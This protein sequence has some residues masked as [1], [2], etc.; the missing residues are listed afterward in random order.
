[1]DDAEFAGTCIVG[2]ECCVIVQ[3]SHCGI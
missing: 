3:A 1:V 2:D